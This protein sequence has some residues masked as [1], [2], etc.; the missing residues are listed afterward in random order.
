MMLKAEFAGESVGSAER[1]RRE[2]RQVV[3]VMRTPFVEQA[4]QD[5]VCENLRI[6]QLLEA[7][8]RLVS[9]RMLVQASHVPSS[10]W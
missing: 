4:F 5:R 8:K 3:D 10:E 6:K 9:A 1:F 2:P 7:V